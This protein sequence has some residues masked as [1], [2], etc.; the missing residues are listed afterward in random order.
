MKEKKIEN[1]K[2]LLDRIEKASLDKNE[3]YNPSITYWALT[4]E[5]KKLNLE[6]ILKIEVPKNIV[7]YNEDKNQIFLEYYN[8]GIKT[9]FE[10][11]LN[12]ADGKAKIFVEKLNKNNQLEMRPLERTFFTDD[13]Y[14]LKTNLNRAAISY[15]SEGNQILSN[16]RENITTEE[17]YKNI[18]F[19]NQL[20]QMKEESD[21]INTN[22]KQRE[23]VKNNSLSFIDRYITPRT[24]EYKKFVVDTAKT[25]NKLIPQSLTAEDYLEISNRWLEEMNKSTSMSK[26]MTLDEISEKSTHYYQ[27]YEF[28]LQKEQEIIKTQNMESKEPI[29]YQDF[30]SEIEKMSA[31]EKRILYLL[32]KGTQEWEKF[33]TDNYLND[34]EG[35]IQTIDIGDDS[36]QKINGLF[37]SMKAQFSLEQI[38]DSVSTQIKNNI[39][40]I[41]PN[42]DKIWEEIQDFSPKEKTY[43]KL[44]LDETTSGFIHISTDDFKQHFGKI[45]NESHSKITEIIQSLSNGIEKVDD[46]GY[47]F[48][49]QDKKLYENAEKLLHRIKTDSDF[50]KEIDPIL[51]KL[52]EKFH[53]SKNIENNTNLSFMDKYFTPMTQGYKNFVKELE[54]TTPE[55]FYQDGE[56]KFTEQEQ[57]YLAIYNFKNGIEN[58]PK[59]ITTEKK[60]EMDNEMEVEGTGMSFYMQHEKNK[61]KM[62]KENIIIGGK[63]SEIA[64]KTLTDKN[65]LSLF[66]KNTQNTIN[67]Y[68]R[69]TP[70]IQPVALSEDDKIA[71]SQQNQQNKVS[72]KVE[73]LIGI[74]ANNKEDENLGHKTKIFNELSEEEKVFFKANAKDIAI[75]SISEI[76]E[77]I[78]EEEKQTISQKFDAFFKQIEEKPKKTYEQEEVINYLKNQLMYL[79]F[80]QDEKLHQQLE[81]SVLES[82]NNTK[83]HL[84]VP[85]DKVQEGNHAQFLINFHKSDK[86]GVYLNSFK[87]VLVVG[88]TGEER[89]H[90]FGAN[91]FTAKEAVNLLEG[92]AVKAQFTNKFTNELDDVFVQLKLKEEKNEFNNYQMKMFNKNFGINTKDIVDKSPLIF[93]G[94][95]AEEVKKMVIKSLEKGNIVSV[96]FKDEANKEMNG[97]AIL[98]P[99]YKNINLYDEQMNRVNTNKPI[100]GLEMDNQQQKNNAREQSIRRTPH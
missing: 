1:Q 5:A 46:I 63:I 69:V 79:G 83:F 100:K 17:L 60:W 9:N 58:I 82:E 77:G 56:R 49:Q 84:A 52:S 27:K 39:N 37:N 86:G 11:V 10:T 74:I 51:S 35:Y 50:S 67:E 44:R 4:D 99:Q 25:Q 7:E 19:I 66:D 73:S 22:Y 41:E 78:S 68:M 54:N 90:S 57:K 31:E 88:E 89:T 76:Q 15:I 28:E 36:H 34:L 26:G 85:Y 40:D 32:A 42:L 53:Q 75:E 29:S 62:E 33:Q 24:K 43:F 87:G 12:L 6:V 23:H 70:N 59:T 30:I 96:K 8:H 55:R 81:K 80:G 2:L 3:D 47:L 97:K 48:S 18:N 94:E 13:Y 61:E 71:I 65:Y 95:N 98:N 45:S 93:E 14:E 91:K 20:L 92:R 38:I 72:E 64:G 16:L 21:Y